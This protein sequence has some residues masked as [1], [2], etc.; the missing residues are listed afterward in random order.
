MVSTAYLV[1]V[2]YLIIP[3]VHLSDMHDFYSFHAMDIRGND[4]S[5]DEFRGKVSLVVNVASEC[6]YT[7]SHYKGLVKLYHILGYGGKFTVLA[8]PSDQF[9]GQEPGENAE[10]EAFAKDKY[11]VEFPMFAKVNVIG[12]SAHPAWK[13]LAGQANQAPDWNFWKYLVDANGRVVEAWGP[14]T[15]VKDIFE[16][17]RSEVEKISGDDIQKQKRE[18]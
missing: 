12:A 15:S 16:R 2:L 7:D 3:C 5:L 14:K 18:L 11:K 10:I 13:S 6:G 17:V 9:G 4:L 1:L 8:F